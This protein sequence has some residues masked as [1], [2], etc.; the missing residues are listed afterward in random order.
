MSGTCS[1]AISSVS[2]W[3]SRASSSSPAAAM[4]FHWM[5]FLDFFS[6]SPMPSSTLVMS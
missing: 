2:A 3:M 1:C 4:G 6:I 5:L